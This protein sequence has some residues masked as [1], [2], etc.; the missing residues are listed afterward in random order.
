MSEGLA[1][2]VQQALQNAIETYKNLGYKCS[3]LNENYIKPLVEK[4]RE[5]LAEYRT[6]ESVTIYIKKII[7][8]FHIHIYKL[9]IKL[10]RY[11][12]SFFFWI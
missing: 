12:T 3:Y 1:P 8:K 10:I 4:V 2:E 11:L 5:Q 9:L 6:N 7:L